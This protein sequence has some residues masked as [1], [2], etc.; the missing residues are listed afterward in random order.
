MQV[1]W[2]SLS[3]TQGP[4]IRKRGALAPKRILPIEKLLDGGHV[5]ADGVSRQQTMRE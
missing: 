1:A 5:V 4:A 2:A 3:I